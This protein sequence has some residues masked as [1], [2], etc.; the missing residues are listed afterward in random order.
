MRRHHVTVRDLS[1]GACSICCVTTTL[2]TCQTCKTGLLYCIQHIAKCPSCDQ[3]GCAHHTCKCLACDQSYCTNHTYKCISCL[4]TYCSNHV[5]NLSKCQSCLAF[6]CSDH[7]NTLHETFEGCKD[8]CGTLKYCVNQKQAGKYEGA[9]QNGIETGC[10]IFTWP[11]GIKTQHYYRKGQLVSEKDFSIPEQVQFLVTKEKGDWED[12]KTREREELA[13]EIQLQ[14]NEANKIINTQKEEA[15]KFI[16]DSKLQIEKQ[17]V[18]LAKSIEDSNIQAA[19]SIEDS[20]L[21]AAKFIEDSKLQIKKE[22]E[23]LAACKEA[24]EKEKADMSKIYKI[25]EEWVKLNIGGLTYETSVSTLT[26]FSSIF[27]AMLSGRYN[28]KHDDTGCIVAKIDR[29]G[30]RFRDILD[31][32]RDGVV[33]EDLSKPNKNIL[34]REAQYYQLD[35][36]I[37]ALEEE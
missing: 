6:C 5:A 29:D 14:K 36:L 7:I 17:K 4:K 27:S 24:F 31:F 18:D 3:L 35:A 28:I 21:Q 10:G 16:E 13:L 8:G 26:K 37:K 25:Q 32:L 34:L 9:W 1:N 2:H 30:K 11:T 15:A 23:V 33:P 19:K 12:T 20:K 22:Y